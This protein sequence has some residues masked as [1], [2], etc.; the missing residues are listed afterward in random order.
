MLLINTKRFTHK[1]T[2]CIVLELREDL[3]CVEAHATVPEGKE[4]DEL[5]VWRSDIYDVFYVEDVV[6]IVGVE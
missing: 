3:I 1:Y 2:G 6:E 5:D 4:E